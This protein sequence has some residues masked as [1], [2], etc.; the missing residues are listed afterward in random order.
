MKRESHD[1]PIFMFCLDMLA[2]EARRELPFIGRLE[3]L[4]YVAC[5]NQSHYKMLSP[6]VRYFEVCYS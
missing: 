3:T 4:L 6:D 5:C 2:I 1:K